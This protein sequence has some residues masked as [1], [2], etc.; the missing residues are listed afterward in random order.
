MNKENQ[1]FE[2]IVQFNQLSGQE[3][4]WPAKWPSEDTLKLKLSLIKEELKELEAE[5]EAK[6][7]FYKTAKELADVLFTVHGLATALG[8]HS[9]E[10]LKE[11]SESNLSKYSLDKSMVAESVKMLNSAE[12]KDYC[13]LSKTDDYYF[14]KRKSDGKV[15]KPMAYFDPDM[16]SVVFVKEDYKA[17]CVESIAE[18]VKAKNAARS[19]GN[20]DV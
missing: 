19:G 2:M 20:K 10:C 17:L 5:L 14:V 12:G 4:N 8:I 15:L 6:E 13:S 9:Q 18:A 1:T 11:V 7:S 16:T 3:V